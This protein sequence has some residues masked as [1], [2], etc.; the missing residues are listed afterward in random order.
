MHG[1]PWYVPMPA[2]Q[3]E[4][5]VAAYASAREA[6]TG[7]RPDETALLRRREA[8]E[9]HERFQA[10]LHNAMRAADPATPDRAMYAEAVESVLVTLAARVDTATGTGT[11]TDADIDTV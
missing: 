5:F 9:A 3:V 7:T 1:G 8:W 11:G 10:A 4:R 6:L 2:E